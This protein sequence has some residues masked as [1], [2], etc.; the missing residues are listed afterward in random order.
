MSVV[1]IREEEVPKKKKRSSERVND[2]DEKEDKGSALLHFKEHLGEQLQCN[3]EGQMRGILL[4]ISNKN[5]SCFYKILI[6]VKKKKIKLYDIHE[7][8]VP[9]ERMKD[10]KSLNH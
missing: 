5:N 10:G 1:R 3:V 7:I 9:F 4:G 6:S 8:N 2:D